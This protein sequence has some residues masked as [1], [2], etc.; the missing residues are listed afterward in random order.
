[1]VVTVGNT[2]IVLPVPIGVPP[3]E[4]ANHCIIAPVPIVPPTTVKSVP[5]PRQRVAMPA[6]PV[7]ATDGEFTVIV[8][9]A[10]VVVLQVP[11]YRTK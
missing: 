8:I 4:P 10:Q 2:L 11:A 5:A 3:Q 9:D 6:M 1:M 7:G